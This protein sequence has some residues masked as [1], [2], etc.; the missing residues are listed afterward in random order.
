MG[1]KRIRETLFT[2]RK[3]QES[4]KQIKSM[5]QTPYLEAASRS[6]N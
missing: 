3:K 2:A 5:Q 6:A 1:K 4:H